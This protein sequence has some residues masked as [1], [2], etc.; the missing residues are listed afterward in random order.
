MI[1]LIAPA[2][3]ATLPFHLLELGFINEISDIIELVVDSVLLLVNCITIRNE[4]RLF[5]TSAKGPTDEPAYI[6][7][8]GIHPPRTALGE[9]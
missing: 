2:I 4:Y 3:W 7:K 8:R 6:A 5:Q 9:S 1:H